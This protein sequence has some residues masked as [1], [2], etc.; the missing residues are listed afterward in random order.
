LER[1]HTEAEEQAHAAAKALPSR[2]FG[3]RF[4]FGDARI[5][6]VWRTKSSGHS[7]SPG[8]RRNRENPSYHYRNNHARHPIFA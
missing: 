2:L 1:R 3:I 7:A 4:P 8:A 5:H 6:L